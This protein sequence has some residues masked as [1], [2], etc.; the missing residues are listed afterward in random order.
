[1]K[2]KIL[3]FGTP[4]I[5][6][7]TLEK[8]ATMK[9]YE[10]VGVGVFPDRKV[11]RQQILTACPV[12]SSA[13]K[14]GL[15]IYEIKN[16]ESLVKLTESLD[17]DL[18]LIIAFGM[19]FP[20]KIL[21]EKFI[22]VHFSLLPKYRGAS[23]VQSAILN[24][25]SKFGIT[26]QNMA[27]KLDAGDVLSQQ[28]FELKNC[29]TS[30]IWNFLSNETAKFLPNFLTEIFLGKITRTIQNEKDATFCHKFNKN[31]GEIFPGKMTAQEIYHKF[32]AFNV[33]PG[34]FFINKQGQRIKVLSANLKQ[35][36]EN[37]LSLK[38]INN[39]ELWIDSLQ[40]AGK[41]IMTDKEFK[42]GNSL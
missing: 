6:V 11:G 30:Y 21:S 40:I 38:C 42:Q 31:D 26:W 34:I 32:L 15:K 1:M 17:F 9:E 24:G 35:E 20:G 23:P 16:K 27:E 39:S 33:W 12:K 7:P 29:S 37:N 13:E 5:A 8:L 41:K 4:E 25:E 18:A 10:I 2:K 14:L 36:S 3:F 28:H 19:I 22:N